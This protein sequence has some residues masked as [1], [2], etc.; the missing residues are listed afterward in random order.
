MEFQE[1]THTEEKFDNIKRR[2]GKIVWPALEELECA[3][4]IGYGHFPVAGQ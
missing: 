3:P 4:E 2:G 1:A